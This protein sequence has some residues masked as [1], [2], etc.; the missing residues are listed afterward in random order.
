MNDAALID[1]VGQA[2]WGPNWK[3]PMAEAVR[4][5]KNAVNDWA[6]GRLPVPSGVWNELSR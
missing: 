2:L 4:H 1:D 6:T 3:G 5:E